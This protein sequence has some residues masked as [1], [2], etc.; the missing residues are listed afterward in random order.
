MEEKMM[1]NCEKYYGV[2][3]YFEKG[4]EFL[5]FTGH[6]PCYVDRQ[7]SADDDLLL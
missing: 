6:I 5:L 1:K 7:S 3:K 2:N 4:F